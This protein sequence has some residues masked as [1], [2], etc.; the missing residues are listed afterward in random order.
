LNSWS[1]RVS[2][3]WTTLDEPLAHYGFT[4][5][6]TQISALDRYCRALWDWNEKINL[7][8]HTDYD[9]FVSRDLQ[10]SAQLA[11]LLESGEEVL[12]VGSGGGVPGILLAILRPDLQITLCESVQKKVMVL[13]DIVQ[14]LELPVAVQGERAEE[15]LSDFRF[16]SLVARA[17]GPLEKMLTWFAPHWLA[18][19]RL[20][21]IK[22]PRWT[23][24]REEAARAGLLRGLQIEVRAK[25]PMPGT[26]SDSVILEVRRL[27]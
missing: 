27:G 22:G 6:E 17:V 7:T 11:A 13:R 26:T 3:A 10:D 2:K 8:R 21:A 12:D 18:F 15:L 4:L 19:D 16:H 20:L 25:Y 14:Q 9:K 24:E 5:T 1:F 23:E